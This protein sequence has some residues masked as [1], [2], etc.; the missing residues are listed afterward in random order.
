MRVPVGRAGQ[1]ML[2]REDWSRAQAAR[3]TYET[4]TTSMKPVDR[5]SIVIRQS[6]SLSLCLSVSRLAR[7]DPTLVMGKFDAWIFRLLGSCFGLVKFWNNYFRSTYVVLMGCP[8]YEYS[9]EDSHVRWVW[10]L[11]SNLHG[12]TGY[13]DDECYMKRCLPLFN[14]TAHNFRFRTNRVASCTHAV[15]LVYVS[16]H[17]KALVTICFRAIENKSINCSCLIY[18][19][20]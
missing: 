11:K 2:G 1:C 17:R 3:H 9:H 18:H 13:L 6:L 14:K 20:Q 10:G 16:N 12:I 15:I 4:T 5:A 19:Q 8:G 7:T